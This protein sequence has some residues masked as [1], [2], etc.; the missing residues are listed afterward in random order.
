MAELF[1]DLYNQRLYTL[2]AIGSQ[3]V[4]RNYELYAVGDH[5]FHAV[6]ELLNLA[7]GS[8]PHHEE[9]G[10]YGQQDDQSESN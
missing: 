3:V 9:H 8:L 4:I 2:P 1:T 10:A 6:A 5:A 7:Y